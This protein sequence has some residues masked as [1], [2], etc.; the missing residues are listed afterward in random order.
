MNM[1]YTLI[2]SNFDR[3]AQEQLPG[4][5]QFLRD[6]GFSPDDG[7]AI[8]FHDHPKE[9]LS[10]LDALTCKVPASCIQYVYSRQYIPEICLDFLS[11]YEPSSDLYLFTGDTFGN[12][13]CTRLSVRLGGSSLT[14][15]V[16]LI[17]GSSSLTVKKK[18]YSGHVLGTFQ[19]K[20]VPYFV[21][22]DK[23][24]AGSI[25]SYNTCKEV[26]FT[27]TAS[28]EDYDIRISTVSSEDLFS[29]SPCVVIGG[30]GLSNSGNASKLSELAESV[31]IPV[32][33]SRPCVM[34]A[35]LPMDRLTGV[36]GAVL[37][38]NLAIL[39]GISG[40]PAFYTG[41]EKCRHIISINTDPDAPI[42]NKSDLAICGDCMDIFSRFTSLV[43][44][45][46]HE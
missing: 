20:K 15:A 1:K 33:G 3:Q 25:I 4:L 37:Q 13:L 8:I 23:N 36:S 41:V 18:I 44:E 45:E 38:N 17:S 19:M 35:W 24:Y 29:D 40:A 2:I 22:V 6:Q 16:S 28:S 43:K 32:A 42:V 39:L 9:E 31:S 21:S 34:N 12:E 30:R 5:G 7:S 14:D 46:C 11:S 26:S 27:N 10:S